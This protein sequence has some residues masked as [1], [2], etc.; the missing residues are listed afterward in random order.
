MCLGFTFRPFKRFIFCEYFI[1][2]V[3]DS[4]SRGNLKPINN[5]TYIVMSSYGVMSSNIS[6]ERVHDP[7]SERV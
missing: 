6:Y 5:C 3:I 4:Y 1:M 2:Q 7:N